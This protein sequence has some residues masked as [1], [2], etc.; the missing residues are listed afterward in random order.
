MAHVTGEET[1]GLR[2]CLQCRV[3]GTLSDGA[4]TKAKAARLPGQAPLPR[5]RLS[6]GRPAQRGHS[7]PPPPFCLERRAS[8]AH[9]S[10]PRLGISRSAQPE[11]R[12]LRLPRSTAAGTGRGPGWTRR[13]QS[14]GLVSTERGP[15]GHSGVPADAAFRGR[16]MGEQ[17]TGAGEG[18]GRREQSQR[19]KK[20]GGGPHSRGARWPNRLQGPGWGVGGAVRKSWVRVR[21]EGACSAPPR[22]DAQFSSTAVCVRCCQRCADHTSGTEDKAWTT[23]LR[24][25]PGTGPVAARAPWGVEGAGA[26]G[27]PHQAQ[28]LAV[29]PQAV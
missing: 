13:Q 1:E 2:G 16:G 4:R 23:G 9:V 28:S 19:Q 20:G 18:G 27:H 25:A 17:E 22:P 14:A 5:T 24:L 10:L 3:P 21:R 12:F 8:R 26:S 6:K 11:P 29:P 7:R 15:E